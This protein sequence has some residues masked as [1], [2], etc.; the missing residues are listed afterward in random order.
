MT[1]V[2][3]LADDRRVVM[4]AD[5]AGVSFNPP[6]E[7][8]NLQ[9]P[10]VFRSGR[11]VVG[12]AASWRFGQILRH[13][14]EWPAPPPGTDLIS[15]FVTEWIGRFREVLK[16]QGFLRIDSDHRERG[17]QALVGYE[18]QIIVVNEKFEVSQLEEPYT[19]IGGGRMVAYGALHSLADRHD[20][21]LEQRAER[22]LDAACRYV[23]GIRGPF[24]IEATHPETLA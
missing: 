3:A 10:K 21:S 14:V 17:G 2:L 13:H 23:P 15:F 19:S 22:A 16:Q 11:Y 5:S 20:L 1:C 18:S 4:A 24:V 9:N 12:Y 7:M 8:Y 6:E